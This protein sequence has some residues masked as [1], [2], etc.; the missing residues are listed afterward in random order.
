MVTLIRSEDSNLFLQSEV[1]EVHLLVYPLCRLLGHP[2]RF[3][4]AESRRHE[5][6]DPSLVSD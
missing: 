2:R 6:G 3:A 4:V 1:T 5:E